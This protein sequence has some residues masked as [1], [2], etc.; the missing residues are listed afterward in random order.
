MQSGT[1]CFNKTIFK[2]N[3]THFWP[4][5]GIYLVFLLYA[6]PLTLL[7]STENPGTG[8]KA[9]KQ[10]ME[11]N[12][13]RY[14]TCLGGALTPM[15]VF[16]AATVCAMTVFFYLY[17]NRSANMIHA[18]PVSRK[19]LYVTNVVS[20]FL[21][22]IVPQILTFVI[23]AFV[24]FARDISQL[25]YLLYWLLMTM[26]MSLFAYA[27]AIV[28]GMLTGQL[29]A[30]PV[31]YVIANFLYVGI[32]F[33]FQILQTEMVY[34]MDHH[35][36][37]SKGKFLS[38]LYYL[39]T[40]VSIH[41]VSGEEAAGSLIEVV[42]GKAVAI[43]ALVGVLLFFVGYLIY[44]KKRLETVG[45]CIAVGWLKPVFR[46]GSAICVAIL[47]A[48]LVA[49]VNSK[50]SR[51]QMMILALLGAVIS[52]AV[53]FFIAQMFLAKSFKVFEKRRITECVGV[54]AVSLLLVAGISMDAVGI[55]KKIPDVGELKAVYMCA[56]ESIMADE[57]EKMKE[58]I[59]LHKNIIDAKDGL[60]KASQ[61][62]KDEGES[63]RV[64]FKYAYKDG[65]YLYRSYELAETK[66]EIQKKDSVLNQILD[67]ENR[68][69]NYMA[70][71][72][73]RNYKTA[74]PVGISIDFYSEV[75]DTYETIYMSSEYLEKMYEALKQ[76]IKEG[77]LK[78]IPYTQQ[79]DKF[80]S[81]GLS[82]EYY[83]PKG[84]EQVDIYG[85][86][87]GYSDGVWK[88]D[89][90]YVKFNVDCKHM[91]KVIEEAG[92]LTENHKLRTES[93]QNALLNE[94]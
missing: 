91:L 16:V 63:P 46:W 12:L 90:A 71:L 29:L 32:R 10:I 94:Q 70:G 85:D 18:L 42:G 11:D 62:K 52:G 31:F 73:G 20:G 78:N 24:C 17:Q 56:D 53:A 1:S 37:F 80:Y 13:A 35:F 23:T 50:A 21:F 7:L 44:R 27:G 19:E 28:I 92:L 89:T 87:Y 34:G 77:N 36:R 48:A 39:E 22:L 79:E 66:K 68:Y 84:I 59:A 38:P 64:E 33:I 58:L 40:N 49:G 14:T 61:S 25:E 41:T 86:E 60:L 45:D 26:G 69:D 65:T 74:K 55:E 2:K 9:A 67:V 43:Y 3:I 6:L 75:N 93:E 76:D 4:I 15:F 83:N 88:S 72:F 51:T 30:V 54:V 57:P 82:I 8:A 47:A 81:S 5:W